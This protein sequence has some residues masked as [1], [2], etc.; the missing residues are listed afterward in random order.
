MPGLWYD[1]Q[2]IYPGGETTFK[3]NKGIS[4]VFSLKDYIAVENPEQAWQLLNQDKN[5]VI[6]GGL[7]WMKMGKKQYHTGIDLKN[8]RLDRITQKSG[9]IEIGAMVSLRQ[10]ETSKTLSHYFGCLF[11][12]ALAPIV[13]IQFRNQATL[14]GS[15]YSRFGFS[16]VITA[17]VALETSVILYHTGTIPLEDFL[18][19]PAKRDLLLGVTIKKR[20]TRTG[21]HALRKTATDFPIISLAVSRHEEAWKICAGARPG[22]ACPARKTA[23]QLPGH[24]DENQIQNACD[25]LVG[26]LSFGTDPRGSRDYRIAMAKVLLKRGITQI[27]E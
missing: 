12:H 15:V 4:N 20:L 2:K 5:N 13:G 3:Y 27:C 17:L 10:M 9:T 24:P 16:D 14:G 19:L 18:S 21:Y 1:S 7:L 26:E 11:S 6:L 22:R 8:L 25:A 23:A